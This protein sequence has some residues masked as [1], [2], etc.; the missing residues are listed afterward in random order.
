MAL[1]TGSDVLGNPSQSIKE[2][3]VLVTKLQAKK[4][5]KWWDK[6]CKNLGTYSLKPWTGQHC[7][8]TVM[9]SLEKAGVIGT[10]ILGSISYETEIADPEEFYEHFLENLTHQAVGI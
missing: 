3:Q 7:T 8:S 9:E 2:T 5:K 6:K 1:K 10:G 4:I